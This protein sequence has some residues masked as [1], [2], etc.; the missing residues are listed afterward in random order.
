MIRPYGS[1]RLA[2]DVKRDQQAFFGRRTDWHQIGVAPFEMSEQQGTILIEH[3]SAGA[4]IARGPTSDVGIPHAG[5]G[6]PIE[7]FAVN[8]RRFAIPRQQAKASGVTLGN[9]QDRFSQCLKNG[10]RRVG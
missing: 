8:V 1:D 7:P 10:A 6:W 4:E 2:G 3:V 9:I 5:D